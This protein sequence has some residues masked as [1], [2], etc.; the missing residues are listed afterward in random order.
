MSILYNKSLLKWLVLL[1]LLL[2]IV[3]FVSFWFGRPS[4]SEAGAVL[5]L[6][7]PSQVSVGDEV[8]Y[9]LTIGNDSRVDLN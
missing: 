9:K 3:S 2:L 8:T 4:F 7:G 6:D 5:K 1:A